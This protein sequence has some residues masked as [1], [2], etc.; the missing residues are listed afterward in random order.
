MLFFAR[1][2][3][4]DTY[5]PIEL[6]AIFERIVTAGDIV[7]G[8]ENAFAFHWTQNKTNM[9]VGLITDRVAAQMLARATDADLT[10]PDIPE[11]SEWPCQLDHD[12][13]ND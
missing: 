12:P 9:R 6:E 3:N 8:R 11:P 4:G 1:P 7:H 13:L 5:T 10:D 2:D